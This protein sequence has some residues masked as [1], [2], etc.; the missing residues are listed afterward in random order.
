MPYDKD[1]RRI[2]DLS[3]VLGTYWTYDDPFDCDACHGIRAARVQAETDELS[4]RK[5]RSY[6]I[7][8]PHE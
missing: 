5:D 6:R 4:R 1:N 7:P 2:H 8:N 3:E